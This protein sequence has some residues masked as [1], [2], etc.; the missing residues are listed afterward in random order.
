MFAW[1]AVDDRCVCVQQQGEAD[2]L[3][4]DLLSAL[5]KCAL[6]FV[7]LSAVIVVVVVVVLKCV[8]QTIQADA[9]V[10]DGIATSAPR[11]RK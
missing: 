5:S 3:T 6:I 9:R 1:S 10:V 11:S 8:L 7:F 2:L 4:A